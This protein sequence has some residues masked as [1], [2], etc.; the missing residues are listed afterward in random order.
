MPVADTEAQV[1][2]GR[3]R[4]TRDAILEAARHTFLHK[5]FHRATVDD[6]M[7]K[8]KLAHGTFY[9][10]FRNKQEALYGLVSAAMSSIALPEHDW[11]RED[12]FVAVRAD[13]AA[14][15]RHFWENRDLCVVWMEA[16]IYDEKITVARD[17]IRRPFLDRIEGSIRWGIGEGIIPPI[18]VAV[19]TR[20]L[21]TMGEHFTLD[22]LG[23]DAAAVDI[24]D[25]AH[26]MA[27]IW[28]RGLGFP[29]PA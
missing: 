18:D 11:D 8:A 14:Y 2:E 21:A 1:Q 23:S 29:V 17:R 25:I 9:R 26:T 6:I 27:L 12:M 10:Y 5:G 22:W 15:F 13:L 7:R 20:A 3:T 24:D 4:D 28:C 16:A 19:A